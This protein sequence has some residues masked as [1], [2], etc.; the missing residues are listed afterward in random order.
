MTSD[1]KITIVTPSFNQGEFIE[2]TILSVLNQTYRN[3]EYIVV[4]GNST[5]A[6]IDVINRYRDRI[7]VVIIEPDDGQSDAINKGFRLATGDL[8][9]WINSDDVLYPDCVEKIVELYRQ[10]PDGA[11]YYHSFNDFI[12]RQ[13]EITKTYQHVIPD[14]R[15][16]LTTDYSV[17]QQGSFYKTDLVRQ[18]GCLDS[19]CYY[20][21]DLDLFLRLLD[22]API[23]CTA[24]CSHTGFRRHDA[25][26]TSEGQLKFLKNIYRTLRQHH[27]PWFSSAMRRIYWYAFKG[28]IKKAISK[29]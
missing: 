23:Y 15:H 3:I 24:D 29:F 26:K 6:S 11:I 19:D 4:D 18:V 28:I 5:D 20:C 17:I 12:D 13:G 27:A 21:M 1:I 16:L 25:T 10:H 2:K 22:L 9:G 8:V 14:K 7:D